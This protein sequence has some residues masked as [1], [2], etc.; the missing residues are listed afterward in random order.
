MSMKASNPAGSSDGWRSGALRRPGL[1]RRQFLASAGAAGVVA[2]A[3][4]AVGREIV[5]RA[6]RH[7]GPARPRAHSGHGHAQLAPK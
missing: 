3:A 4:S 1:P 7:P 2:L 5:S 6:L